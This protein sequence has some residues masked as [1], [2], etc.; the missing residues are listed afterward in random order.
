[1]TIK[2]PQLRVTKLLQRIKQAQDSKKDRSCRWIAILLGKM[3]AM[4]PA[5]GEALLL[6]RFLQIDLTRSLQ[7]NRKENFFISTRKPGVTMVEN[8]SYIEEWTS[9]PKVANLNSSS[10]NSVDSSDTD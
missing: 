10:N 9:N 2:V 1:M 5:V 6:I 8:E 7:K 3:T 4:I